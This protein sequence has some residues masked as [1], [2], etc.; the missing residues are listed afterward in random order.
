M[1]Y[2]AARSKRYSKSAQNCGQQSV[3]TQDIC[4]LA[5]DTQA[6]IVHFLGKPLDIQKVKFH[7]PILPSYCAVYTVLSAKVVDTTMQHWCST[8]S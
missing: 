3:L 6:R 8:A 2:M 4:V 5:L 1:L 7:A